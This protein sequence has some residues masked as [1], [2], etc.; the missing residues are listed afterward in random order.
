MDS[1]ATDPVPDTTSW[2]D[3]VDRFVAEV[4]ALPPSDAEPP[5]L[6]GVREPA[7]RWIPDFDAFVLEATRSRTCP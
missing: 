5:F 2:S 3:F 1:A 6:R 4:A 7:S